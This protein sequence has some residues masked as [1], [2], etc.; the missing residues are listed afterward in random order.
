MQRVILITFGM[1]LFCIMAVH[2]ASVPT[3]H[4]AGNQGTV[5]QGNAYIPRGTILRAQLLETLDSKTCKPGD[6]FSFKLLH[7]VVVANTLVI[8][9]GTLGEGV[10]KSVKRAGMFG[11]GGAIELEAVSIKT[12]NGIEVPLTLKQLNADGGHKADLD[13]YDN[14][15]SATP[16]LTIGIMSGITSGTEVQIASGAKLMIT[17][18]ANIDL[19]STLAELQNTIK[20]EPV[21]SKSESNNVSNESQSLTQ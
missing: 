8:K 13:W 6:K 10:V 7:N 19:Q 2:A 3:D 18:P 21:T 16:A 12:R 1:L 11:R 17:L 5:V 15:S 20:D 4:G 14:A 9:Q